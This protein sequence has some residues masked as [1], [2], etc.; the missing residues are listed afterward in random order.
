MI[1]DGD[2]IILIGIIFGIIP[3]GVGNIHIGTILTSTHIG[4]ILGIIIHFIHIGIILIG[5][6]HIGINGIIIGIE[7]IIMVQE[8]QLMGNIII[9]SQEILKTQEI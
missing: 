1:V 7:D 4:I 9:K 3:I 2:G 8:N 6:I 5:T